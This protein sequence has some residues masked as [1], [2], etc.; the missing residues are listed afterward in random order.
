MPNI[1]HLG[2]GNDANFQH[3]L[4]GL[5]AGT[6][7]GWK[8]WLGNPATITDLEQR[9][10]RAGITGV[11][12]SNQ[13][14]LAKLLHAQADFI[15]PNNRRGITLDDYQ[16]SLLHTPRGK[17]PVVIINPLE[18]LMSVP[19]S[20]PAAKRFISKVTRPESWY[21]ATPFTWQLFDPKSWEAILEHWRI[22]ATMIAI[23]IE[24]AVG[25]PD[26]RINC[27]G[28]CAYF[29]A[30]HTTECLVIPFDCLYNRAAVQ[31]FNNLPQP[32]V[33]QN[34]LYDSLY[35]LRWNCP[36][37][38]WLFDTQHLF[39]SMFSEYPKR[40]D[41]ISA[42]AIRTIRYWKDDGKSGSL[43]DY[44]RYNARD[45]WAT[46][47]SF[48]SLMLD[49]EPYAIA[50]YLQEFPLVFPC[51]TCEI[52]GWK[53]D[54]DRMK[55]VRE[56]KEIEVLRR[57]AKFLTMIAAPNFNLNSPQQVAKLF[58]VLG[59]GS[60]PTTG[61]GDML[62]AQAA[63]P[64][65]NRILSELVEIK[66]LKKLLSTYFVEGKF[67][68]GRCYYK[69]NPAATD[70]GR[71]A[72]AESSFWCGLQIQNI[73]RGD[74]VKQCFIADE[75]WLLCEP[76]K[77]QSEARC[78]GYLSAETGLIELLEG[79]HEFHS[80]NAAA[81]FGIPYAQIYDEVTRKQL[82][83]PLRDLAKRTN[84]GANYN[85]GATVMLAT[86]GP[87]KVSQA[88]VTLK[89]PSHYS[90]KQVCEH[91]LKVYEATYPKVKGLWYDSIIAEVAKTG[92]LVSP[93]GW[94]RIFFGVPSRGNKPLLNAAVA[95]PP[96]NLS[97]SIINEEFYNVW[98]ATVYNSYFKLGRS[99]E[100]RL[101]GVV[102][103]K[104]QIHDSIPFQYHHSRPDAPG[105]VLSIM[106]TSV[107][108]RGAD[109]VL[110]TMVIPTD[111]KE[112]K[113]RWSELK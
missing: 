86:M 74:T 52:E 89:L 68:H 70:T 92:R 33:M 23:D 75:G 25:D 7:T 13:D 107:Q 43:T 10:E 109:N 49:C 111:I 71:L 30:T 50:N 91:L 66:K 9:C 61:A 63:H 45:C 64:L 76:D 28:Y 11:V 27:V 51:L 99:V 14:F 84:H 105:I 108:V 5:T 110:R 41:F 97:V 32:K 12:C 36:V 80:W 18:N 19:W 59:V 42:Y 54:T 83:V 2:T 57:E 40:L 3:K 79:P 98:R 39:H 6:Q 62:K 87:K 96:Q 106:D 17:V 95:H 22:N 34:G 56:Q 77:A 82:N 81:F 112:G 55:V 69:L 90:L 48:V 85:M 35:L 15:P 88:K 73:T 21:T 60:L 100:C 37:H 8:T 65:N 103:V 101:R 47:N 29:A 26:R 44:Y 58:T 93:R 20:V 38:N 4:A 16:G 104:A 24:T 94:T 102:R 1:L 53:I 67:W 46:A 113:P 31:Y 78:V 72:S